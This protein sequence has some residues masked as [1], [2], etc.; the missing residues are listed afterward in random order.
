MKK[1]LFGFNV[2][3]IVEIGIL[4]SIAVVLDL[5]VRIPLGASGSINISMVPLIIIAL[6][7]GWFKTLFAAG[8]VYGITTCLLDGYGLITYPLSYLVG[9]GGICIVGLF[10]PYITRNYG[11]S[12]KKT[13]ICY[14]F[15]ILG[16]L[17]WATLRFF[18]ESLTSVLIYDYTFLAAFAY[19]LGYVYI[20]AIADIVLT[21]LLL[22]VVIRLNKTFKTSYLKS[23]N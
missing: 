5:F 3:D 21:I 8:L 6:R 10:A 9:F 17:S 2:H 18:A 11:I 4:C 7:H 22:Y 19:N 15:I 13:F 12:R 14:V 16:L 1:G 23:I 20:S